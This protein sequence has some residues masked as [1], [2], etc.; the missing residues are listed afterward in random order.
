[1]GSLKKLA[2]YY[3]T[4][5]CISLIAAGIIGLLSATCTGAFSMILLCSIPYVF[6]QCPAIC[7]KLCSSCTD[8]YKWHLYRGSIYMCINTVLLASPAFVNC[9]WGLIMGIFGVSGAVLFICRFFIV[10]KEMQIS[11]QKS[12]F[13]RNSGVYSA[14]NYLK[15]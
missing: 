1:M 14:F 9:M 12:E 4:G 7:A 6:L 10:K 11:Q 3:N 15:K 2:P 5:F 13:I 8:D